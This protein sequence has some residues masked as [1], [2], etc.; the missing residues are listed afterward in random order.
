[1]KE[2]I[3]RMKDVNDLELV[4]AKQWSNLKKSDLLEVEYDGKIYQGL[5]G[6]KLNVMPPEVCVP[7]N[8]P[9][10][11]WICEMTLIQDLGL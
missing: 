10:P 9:D 4:N 8:A 11:T 7:I 6:V 1:M 2:I 3:I 5:N